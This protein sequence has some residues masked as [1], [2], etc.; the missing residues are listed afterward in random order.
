MNA[1]RHTA[2]T[3]FLLMAQYQGRTVVP[4]KDVCRDFFG[5]L[6]EEKLL[7]KALRGELALPIVRIETSQKAQRG[8]HLTDLANYIDQRRNAALKECAQLTGRRQYDEG[9]SGAKNGP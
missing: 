1:N 6:S 7:R 3:L 5:H 2:P 9:P 4:L 8:V